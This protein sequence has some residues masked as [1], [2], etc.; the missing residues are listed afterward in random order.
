MP[1]RLAFW[2]GKGLWPLVPFCLLM[3]SCSRIGVDGRSTV[4]SVWPVDVLLPAFGGRS[5]KDRE[6]DNPGP[7]FL[8]RT[9]SSGTF[10]AS[11]SRTSYVLE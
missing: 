5:V 10:Q 11:S 1:Q 3:P 8:L 6:V 9:E 7:V 4:S 2:G